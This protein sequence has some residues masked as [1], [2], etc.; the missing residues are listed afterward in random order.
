MDPDVSTKEPFAK[1]Q[2]SVEERADLV[3]RDAHHGQRLVPRDD[4]SVEDRLSKFTVIHGV[5]L[6]RAG[7]ACKGWAAISTRPGCFLSRP[8]V[9][10]TVEGGSV[11]QEAR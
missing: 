8:R 6:P 9:R 2:R 10:P 11:D 7:R 1:D 5:V 4:V 3:V